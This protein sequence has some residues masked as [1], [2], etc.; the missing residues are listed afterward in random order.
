MPEILLPSG[1]TVLI[2]DCDAD[3]A[4]LKWRRVVGYATHN[5]RKSDGMR[6]TELLHRVILARIEGRELARGEFTDHINGNRLDNRR[7]NLRLA[8]HKQN[9]C[10]QGIRTDNTSG[11]KGVTWHKQAGRWQSQIQHH[12]RNY[13]LGHFDDPI[14][15]AIAYNDAALKYHGKFARLNIIPSLLQHTSASVASKD[16]V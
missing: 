4:D 2:D 16:F 15:A 13:F 1:E 6:T 9:L 8:T 14:E 3:L 12:R 10:N 7:A 5:I 11:F